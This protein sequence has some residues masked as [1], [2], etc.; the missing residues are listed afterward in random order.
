MN[1]L[2]IRRDINR[3]NDLIAAKGAEVPALQAIADIIS[4]AAR[5]V[6]SAWQA[7]QAASVSGD[8]ER[9]ERDTAIGELVLVVIRP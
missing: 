8:R 3:L 7:F 6:N 9:D 1:N 4:P 2:I 5:K